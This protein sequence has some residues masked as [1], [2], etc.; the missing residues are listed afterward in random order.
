MQW[1]LTSFGFW[2]QFAAYNYER[3]IHFSL[4]SK[5]VKMKMSAGKADDK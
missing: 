3:Q 5:L 4:S 2:T 1:W